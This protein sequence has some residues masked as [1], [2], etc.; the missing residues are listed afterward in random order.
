MT[1]DQKFTKA[2][3]FVLKHEGG[4]IDDPDDPGG[5]TKYGI[6]LNFIKRVGMKYGDL[7]EDGDIDPDDIKKLT[8]EKAI[9]IYKNQ[10]WDRYGY[11]RIA[12]CEVAAKVLDL[13]VNV[14]PI[15]AHKIVQRALRACGLPV[16]Q[17]G[18]LGPKTLSAINALEIG[19]RSFALVASIRSEAACH[20][21]NIVRKFSP[22]FSKY[23]RGWLNRAYD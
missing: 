9:Q 19:D 4:Y 8:K 18:I 22:R 5:V 13:S 14:G 1:E 23:E 7:D 15:N 2:V 20:Y 17:D 10:W 12:S 11:D 3:E 16:V 6:S 21:R